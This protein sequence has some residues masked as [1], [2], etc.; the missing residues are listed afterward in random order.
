MFHALLKP[1]QNYS[2]ST[3]QQHTQDRKESDGTGEGLGP[4]FKRQMQRGT[5]VY[6]G[7]E[8]STF[9]IIH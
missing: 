2:W 1:G 8:S 7:I 9:D 5:Q 4:K 3:Q 6:T